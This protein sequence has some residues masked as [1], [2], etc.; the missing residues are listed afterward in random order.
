MRSSTKTLISLGIPILAVTI[1]TSIAPLVQPLSI[2]FRSVSLLVPAVTTLQ[3]GTEVG[4]IARLYIYTTPGKGNVFIAT[5]P[6]A[7]MDTEATARI[8]FLV[9]TYLAGVNTYS[10]DAYISFNTS[11]LMI[12]GPS[13]GVA[14]TVGILASLRGDHLR[15]DVIATGMVNPDGTV[16][17]VGGLLAKL[18][19]AARSGAKYFLIP[20]GQRYTYIIKVVKKQIGPVVI[21]KEERVPVDLFKVGE[22]L[23]VKV[24]EVSTIRE[25]YR[26]FTGV[27]LS[28]SSPHNVSMPAC[29]KRTLMLSSEEYLEATE[30]NINKTLSFMNLLSSTERTY[31]KNLIKEVNETLKE[32]ELYKEFPYVYASKAFNAAIESTYALYV[33]E[34]LAGIDPEVIINST[35]TKTMKVLN[36]TRPKTL[37]LPKSYEDLE[38]RI[39]VATR[40]ELAREALLKSRELLSKN[41]ILDNALTG[42][43]G[44]LHE[45]A[46]AYWRAVSARDWSRVLSC[47]NRR[48]R[49]SYYDLRDLSRFALYYSNSIIS[50]ATS[51]LKSVGI[52]SDLLTTANDYYAKA[53]R[54]F[55]NGDVYASIGY[56]L[57][58]A[59]Y[60]MI[61]IDSVFI[62]NISK[63]II[64]AKEE[65]NDTLAKL[66]ESGVIPPLTLSYMEFSEV[67][68]NP[69]SKLFYVELAGSYMRLLYYA[70]SPLQKQVTSS[71]STITSCTSPTSTTNVSSTSKEGTKTLPG[72]GSNWYIVT[73]FLMLILGVIVGFIIGRITK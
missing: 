66:Y 20:A 22:K 1:I 49:I 12:E 4:V 68:K 69:L 67:Q 65:V 40:V 13:A 17:P 43:W 31:V 54:F 41:V 32:V 21:T 59:T 57:E 30:K 23:G 16:G 9:A 72:K 53:Y 58:S 36:L 47:F 51:L 50:Y 46:Y 39:A 73:S 60:G 64:A 61:A 33:A 3:N 27:N 29:L 44:A 2:S 62:S 25:A 63:T 18:Q 28:I 52:S 15:K 14:M 70:L 34:V 5:N 56:S 35:T 37:E 7:G 19:A 6:L 71:T 55:K 26:Y 8:A 11:S 45:A 24:V 38:V 48:G 10:V 42:E